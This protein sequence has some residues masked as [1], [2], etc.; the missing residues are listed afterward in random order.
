MIRIQYEL[1]VPSKEMKV[2]M[3]PSTSTPSSEP[4]T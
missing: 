3:M 2:L 1:R 4:T